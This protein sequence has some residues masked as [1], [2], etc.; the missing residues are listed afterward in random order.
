MSPMKPLASPKSIRVLSSYIAWE[1]REFVAWPSW[2][3]RRTGGT[4][5][6]QLVR[7]GC[8]R[9]QPRLHQGHC[10]EPA[11]CFRRTC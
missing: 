1:V 10:I 9:S 3:C 2:P 6:A 8:P 4:P 7:A 5:V 11:G